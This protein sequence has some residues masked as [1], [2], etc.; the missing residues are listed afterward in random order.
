MRIISM[1]EKE[2]APSRIEFHERL[3]CEASPPE[4]LSEDLGCIALGKETELQPVDQGDRGLAPSREVHE[5][6]AVV[7]VHEILELVVHGVSIVELKDDGPAVLHRRYACEHATASRVAELDELVTLLVGQPNVHHLARR[8]VL[9]DRFVDRD[10]PSLAGRPPQTCQLPIVV[11]VRLEDRHGVTLEIEKLL[12]F[13]EPAECRFVTHSLFLLSVCSLI[14]SSHHDLISC[15]SIILEL[16]CQEQQKI[17]IS[18]VYRS[19]TLW[20]KKISSP[21]IKIWFEPMFFSGFFCG[22]ERC[23]SAAFP[24]FRGGG[25]L[26]AA[27]GEM[28]SN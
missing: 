12:G 8:A 2:R 27:G 6:V 13:L 1:I 15:Y 20:I 7:R 17:T 9:A 11:D 14:P 26:A 24:N 19:L 28:R 21:K 23:G 16:S 10:R 5:R 22:F 25:F 18:G 4:W 3:G